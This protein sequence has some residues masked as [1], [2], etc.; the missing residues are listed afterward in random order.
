[1]EDRAREAEVRGLYHLSTPELEDR[2]DSEDDLEEGKG[3]ARWVIL[4]DM[5]TSNSKE[6]D[7][8]RSVGEEIRVVEGGVREGSENVRVLDGSEVPEPPKVESVRTT[9]V[10]GSSG[11]G[12]CRDAQNTSQAR[13]RE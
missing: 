6:G 2:V 3:F 13:T 5:F 12:L 4:K 11:K 9:S 7:G 10:E 1:M 8:F